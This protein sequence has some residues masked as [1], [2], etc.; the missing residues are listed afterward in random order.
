MAG[1]ARELLVEADAESET[2][3]STQDTAAEFLLRVLGADTVLVRT[4]E[5]EASAAG[6]AWLTIRRAAG[7][8]LRMADYVLMV[9]PASRLTDDLRAT[10]HRPTLAALILT[11]RLTAAI[12]AD[13]A[14]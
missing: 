7:F 8:Q 2:E 9:S 10:E 14:S 6:I 11:E 12:H 4:V 3:D 13:L 5:T 1:T